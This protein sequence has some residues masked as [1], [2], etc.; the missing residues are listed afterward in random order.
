[1]TPTFGRILILAGLLL[2]IIGL[3]LLFAPRIP[4]FGKLPGDLSFRWGNS[5]VFIPLATCLVISALLTIILNLF[6]R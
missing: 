6:R 5:R 3:V 4:F 2:V 1:M